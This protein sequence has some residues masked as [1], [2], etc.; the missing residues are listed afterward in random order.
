AEGRQFARAGQALA[1]RGEAEQPPGAGRPGRAGHL[2]G[3]REPVP[4]LAPV[5][6]TAA[7]CAA[8]GPA[9]VDGGAGRT[10]GAI[11]NAGGGGFRDVAAAGRVPAPAAR[12]PRGR[13]ARCPAGGPRAGHRA[14]G[15]VAAAQR[16]TPLWLTGR[17]GLRGRRVSG[18]VRLRQPI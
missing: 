8:V 10:R 6:A 2:T 7:T 16:A 18:P 5:R 14:D 15:R 11:E 4:V 3:T 12:S 13:A 9:W 1:L 17:P